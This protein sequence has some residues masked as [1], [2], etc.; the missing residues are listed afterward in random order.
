MSNLTLFCC[1]LPFMQPSPLTILHIQVALI[2]SYDTFEPYPCYDYPDN[3]FQVLCKQL[4]PLLCDMLPPVSCVQW[5]LLPSS[6]L[7]SLQVYDIY[8]LSKS[9][10]FGMHIRHIALIL[11]LAICL[12]VLSFHFFFTRTLI[13]P[14]THT[15][16]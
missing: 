15:S 13:I 14:G 5:L 16:P 3:L 6:S 2:C 8:L 10:L 9:P 1:F 12:H 4:Y 7:V 11:I